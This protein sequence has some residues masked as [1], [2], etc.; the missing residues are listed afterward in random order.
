M[1]PTEHN[2]RAWDELHRRRSEAVAGTRGLPSQVHRALRDLS[3]KRVLDLLCGTGESAAD[4][5]ALGGT[6]TALD[7]DEQAL[8]VARGRWPSI[9]WIRGEADDLPRELRRGRFDLVYGGGMLAR[10][11]ELEPWATGVA[12]ALDTGGDLLLFDEHPVAQRV[13]GLMH[14]RES[15]FADTLDGTARFWRLGQVV[16]AIARVGLMV[17]ALEEYPQT[18]GNLRHQD[19]RLPGAFLLHAQRP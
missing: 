13:D 19:Q 8:E 14:W 9:L 5:A 11:T 7:P 1:E 16:T 6:V 17:R 4:L 10:L 3:G 15:Y 18:Q 2:L 12:A